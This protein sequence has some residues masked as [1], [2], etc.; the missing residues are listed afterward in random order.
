MYIQ[1]FGACLQGIDGTIVDVEIDISNGLPYFQ[2]VGLPDSSVRESTERVRAAIKNCGAVFPMERITVNL[3]PADIRKEGASFDLAI[4]V[5]ILTASGQLSP[6]KL[7]RCLLIGELSLDGSLRPVHGVLSMVDAA[8]RA[9]V[10][11]VVLPAEN[12]EEASLIEG[13]RIVG[14]DNVKRLLEQNGASLFNDINISCG[15]QHAP[16]LSDGVAAT[17]E[18]FVDVCGQH[19]A[20]RALTIAAAGMHNFLF[21]GPPGSGK[22]MLVRRLP[23]ILPPLSDEESL[24]V[25]KVYSAAGQIRN[26][27][28]L[29]RERPFRNPHHTISTGGLVGAG[30]VPKPGEVSLAH[31]G[32]LF[33]D[34]MPEFPRSVLEVL[35]QPIEDRRV[36]IGRARAV[37]TFPSHFMLAATMNPCPCG[38]WGFSSSNASCTCSSVKV[39]QYRSKMSGPLLDRIDMHVEVPR[40]EYDAMKRTGVNVSS[41]ELR[42]TVARALRRQSERYAGSGIRF[43]GELTGRMLREHCRL[44]PEGEKL[45]AGSFEALGLSVRAHD[46]VLKIA[47]TIADLDECDRIGTPHVAEALQYRC[48]DR[49]AH[50]DK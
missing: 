5:G 48:L 34:E 27:A 1:C 8:K 28:M 15:L 14:I 50:P 44:Q 49:N 38:Y 42:E 26:R 7:G 3:A 20:K 32:V 19:Q 10:T 37:F 40:I 35:R 23:S 31:R 29:I 18:D 46:R 6:E 4:A 39:R 22:T 21:V 30:S 2:I 41:A 25:T 36:T 12:V 17:V 11:D 47:R 45:L 43:N 33:L 16:F 9:G 13:M 24:E